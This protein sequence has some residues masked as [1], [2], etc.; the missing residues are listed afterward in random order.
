VCKP[1]CADF[2]ITPISKNKAD[3]SIILELENSYKQQ[4]IVSYSTLPRNIQIMII[5]SN[6]PISPILLIIIAFIA[7]LLACILVNQK[8]IKRY[9]HKPT[10]SQPMNN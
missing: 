9:E 6:N 8:L 4:K 10:P 7:D 2:P 3:I 5:P 1:I